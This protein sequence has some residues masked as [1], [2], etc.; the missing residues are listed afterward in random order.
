MPP[1]STT[2]SVQFFFHPS[3]ILTHFPSIFY[4]LYHPFFPPLISSSI[5]PSPVSHASF[6][7]SKSRIHL[8]NHP[9]IFSLSYPSI[10]SLIFLFL[11]LTFFHPSALLSK[12][13]HPSFSTTYTIP[14]ILP[15]FSPLALLSNPHSCPTLPFLRLSQHH[16]PIHPL[17]NP[18]SILPFFHPSSPKLT[19]FPFIFHYPSVL[20]DFSTHPFSYRSTQCLSVHPSSKHPHILQALSI[21]PTVY[22][23]IYYPSFQLAFVLT[24]IS[25]H[26]H[27]H[28]SY[29][30]PI[31]SIHPSFHQPIYCTSDCIIIYLSYRIRKSNKLFLSTFH[32]SFTITPCLSP[33]N[34]VQVDT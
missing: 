3:V 18:P 17:V 19:R 6:L 21:C 29:T 23:C 12:T 2:P 34:V 10:H 15:Y 1:L 4:Y 5:Q 26:P 24:F 25:I 33:V 27:R 9:S 14:S 22:S 8:P 16:L 11:I 7:A 30:L 20:T 31:Q 13:S 32:A 28:H